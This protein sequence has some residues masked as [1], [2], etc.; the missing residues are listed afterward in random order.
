MVLMDVEGM[1]EVESVSGSSRSSES[2]VESGSSSLVMA[3]S[4]MFMER[5]MLSWITLRQDARSAIHAL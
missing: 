2:K 5:M 4:I 1:G 3:W